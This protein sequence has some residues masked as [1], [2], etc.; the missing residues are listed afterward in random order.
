M[1]IF[2]ALAIALALPAVAGANPDSSQSA[3]GGSGDRAGSSIVLAAGDDPDAKDDNGRT[4][5]HSAAR[6]GHAEAVDALLAVGADPNP[7][8]SAQGVTPLQI[9][10][11]SDHAD[12]VDA[13]AASDSLPSTTSGSGNGDATDRPR[14][15]FRIFRLKDTH[16]YNEFTLIYNRRKVAI[17]GMRMRL[18]LTR[19]ECNAHILDRFNSDMARLIGDFTRR[20]SAGLEA[21][22]Y[23]MMDLGI[24]IDGDHYLWSD[25]VRTG[26]NFLHIPGEIHRMKWEEKLNCSR[27]QESE[28]TP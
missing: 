8:A 15:R 24:Q 16:G 23:F 6:E 14:G 21:T 7:N 28:S 20:H 17:D 5:L 4:P 13:L 2:Y 27:E 18:S 1:R 9:A 19:R 26:Q 11:E 25:D 12:A 22:E 3:G 10:V